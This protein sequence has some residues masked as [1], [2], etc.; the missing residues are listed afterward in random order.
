MPKLRKNIKNVIHM[1]YGVILCA[2]IGIAAKL[3]STYLSLGSVAIAILLGIVVGNSVDLG[4][5][6]KKGI[7]FS[8]KHI[9]SLAIALMGVNLNYVILKELGYKSIV[10]IIT[11][12][13]V[14]ILSSVFLARLFKWNNKL[15]LLLGIGSGVCGSS[16]IAATERI[17]GADEEDVGL[18]VAIV[19]FLGTIGMFLLP[20]L[21]TTILKFTDIRA[22]IL[23][24]NTLQAVGQV[25]AGGFSISDITGQTAT[26]VKMGRILMLTP[27]ILILLVVFSNKTSAM[28]AEKNDVK[29]H[30]V[31]LFIIG[32]IL[33]SLVST[34]S[35]LP[36]ARI[37]VL[38]TISHYALNIAMAG[39]GMKIT[40]VSILRD[41]KSAL[42]IGSVIFLLQI[43]FSCSAIRFLF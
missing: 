41:G 27:L 13:G 36:E 28:S 35:L 40:F 15:A 10:L 34:F 19:N 42:L 22:G 23:I 14:T 38:G 12:I 8:E 25:T 21:G 11:A 7:A 33:F 1:M 31:P 24:G 37:K 29:T 30:R 5:K 6:F 43:V 18:A 2:M 3:L 20:F 17:I 9:L 32:F 4:E 16:A 26:I 39:I